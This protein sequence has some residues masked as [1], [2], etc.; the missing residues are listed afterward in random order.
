MTYYAL[1]DWFVFQKTLHYFKMS[2]DGSEWVQK[3]KILVEESKKA[4]K[5]AL[6][7]DAPKVNKKV[8]ANILKTNLKI[9]ITGE[10][11]KEWRL[12]L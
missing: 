2:D 10:K 5:R 7:V 1:M 8:I 3:V 12:I 11:S 6:V 9:K 4:K